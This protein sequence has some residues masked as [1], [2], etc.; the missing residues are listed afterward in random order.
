MCLDI[1]AK[2]CGD[3]PLR[4]R[5]LK[6]GG[7]SNWP[8]PPPSKNLLSKSPVKIGLK[9]PR[10]PNACWLLL[11]RMY[12]P[13]IAW[14]WDINVCH[15]FYNIFSIIIVKSAMLHPLKNLPNSD[16]WDDIIC[17]SWNWWREGRHVSSWYVEANG[18]KKNMILCVWAHVCVCVCQELWGGASRAANTH[19]VAWLSQGLGPTRAEWL[20]SFQKHRTRDQNTWESDHG[21]TIV[22]QGEKYS[23]VTAVLFTY[24]LQKLPLHSQLPGRHLLGLLTL[25]LAGCVCV[26]NVDPEF[27][28]LLRDEQTDGSWVPVKPVDLKFKWPVRNWN[29]IQVGSQK[30]VF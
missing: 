25:G 23:H 30:W 4:G 27:A 13:H 22:K 24:F 15:I 2:F 14:L 19:L 10:N 5:D 7:G 12:T 3:R 29:Q 16:S 18:F 8:P 1:H 26:G 28:F 11:I 9:V 17:Q 21:E 6:G 20:G